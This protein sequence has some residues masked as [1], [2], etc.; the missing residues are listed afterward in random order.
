[1]GLGAWIGTVLVGVFIAGAFVA[2]QDEAPR[3]GRVRLEALAMEH[4][5]AAVRD[6]DLSEE[7]ASER[8]RAWAERL[9]AVLERVA[10]ERGVVLLPAQAVAAGAPDYTDEVRRRLR[11]AAPEDGP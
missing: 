3:I 5:E 9:E 11:N 6:G 8:T 1:M 4:I 7:E 2:S 10:E